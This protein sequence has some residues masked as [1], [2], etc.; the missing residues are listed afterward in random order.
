MPALRQNFA[1]LLTPGFREI[2][3]DKFQEVPMQFTKVFHV[4]DSVKDSE[5]DSAISGFGL[6]Q[7]TGEGAPIAYEDPVQG[8]TTTYVHLKYTKGFKISVEMYEDDLYN[9]M[10]KRPAALGRT[11]RRTSENQAALVF[12]NGFNT[13]FLGGDSK[14][15]FSTVH[16]RPDGGNSQSNASSTGITLSE[17]NLETGIIAMRGQLDDKGQ[18]IDVYPRILLVPK[19]LRK[20]ARL[21]I[22]SPMRQG[23]ADNDANY[24]KDDFTSIDWLYLT[25]TTA[26]FLIDPGVHELTWFWRRKPEFK[27]D[28]LFDTE[29]A[30]YKSTMRLSRGWSDWRGVWGSAGDGL[31]YSS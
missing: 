17:L 20:T 24:Y 12:V 7:Q 22:D 6:A 14:P 28:E 2:F 15:L 4:N 16:P 1:V 26:W 23:T 11:M 21:I 9:I 10:K 30:V 3:N 13:S 25:S 18:I 29:F 8:Y 19:E 5:K 27:D 31:A